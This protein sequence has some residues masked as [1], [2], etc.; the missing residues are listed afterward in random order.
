MPKLM[1]QTLKA[2]L[3][4]EYQWAGFRLYPIDNCLLALD[5]NEE[6]VTIFGITDVTVI[7]VNEACEKY[8]NTGATC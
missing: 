7:N 1:E 2:C 3:K 6:P 4:L 5:Y 8:L